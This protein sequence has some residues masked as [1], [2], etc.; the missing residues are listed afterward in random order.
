MPKA[1]KTDTTPPP[2]KL[3]LAASNPP[4]PRRT[5]TECEIIRAIAYERGRGE[6]FDGLVRARG[7]EPG[8]YRAPALKAP[9]PALRLIQ[10]GAQ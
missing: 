8:P 4:P 6:E 10:G 5:L 7:Y 9:R 1:T 3:R 2:K